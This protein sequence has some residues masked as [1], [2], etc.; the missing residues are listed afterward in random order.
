MNKESIYKIIGYNGEYNAS[1]KK[2]IRKLL[3]ENHPDKNGDAKIFELINEV[4]DELENNKVSYTPKK[5]NKVINEKDDID[6]NYCVEMINKIT[7]EKKIYTNILNKKKEKLSKNIADY[8]EFYRNSIDLE[9]YLLSNSQYMSKLKNNKK[10]SV[11][12][13]ILTIIFFILSILEKNLVFFVIFIILVIICVLMIYES[14]VIM[15]KITENHRNKVSSYVGVNAKLR[16]NK[17]TQ[18]RLK[19]EINELNKKINDM[20]NDLR[21]YDNLINNR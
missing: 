10:T 3:K 6:Y 19:E 13:L 15:Q 2:A 1:V 8:K 21:F 20:E 12:L 11:I 9:T 5:S 7:K 16:S 17:N 14:F 18:D 4:K